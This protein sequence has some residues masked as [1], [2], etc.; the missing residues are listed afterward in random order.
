MAEATPS[1]EVITLPLV[2]VRFSQN[3]NVTGFARSW[4]TAAVSEL[5]HRQRFYGRSVPVFDSASGRFSLHCRRSRGGARS[6]PISAHPT[7]TGRN[8]VLESGRVGLVERSSSQTSGL[9]TVR[10]LTGAPVHPKAEDRRAQNGR[11]SLHIDQTS[12]KRRAKLAPRI[13]STRLDGHPRRDKSSASFLKRRGSLY[14]GIKLKISADSPG[15]AM[16]AF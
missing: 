13:F 15:A 11:P 9:P 7:R 12:V 6:R 16:P 10:T 1:I 14:S 5:P 2:A 3:S 8:R 4:P